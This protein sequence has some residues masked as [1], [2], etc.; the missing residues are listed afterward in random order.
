[1]PY[2]IKNISKNTFVLEAAVYENRLVGSNSSNS[3]PSFVGQVISEG[4]VYNNRLG[5]FFLVRMYSQS[6]W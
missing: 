5:F 3:A 2:I 1:M 6:V 4:F